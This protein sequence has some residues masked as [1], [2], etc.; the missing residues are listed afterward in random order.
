MDLS[1]LLKAAEAAGIAVPEEAWEAEALTDY[2]TVTRYPGAGEPVTQQDYGHAVEVAESV[3]R[4][5]E[6]LIG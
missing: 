1:A 4:W 6:G 3:V 2:A 5:A